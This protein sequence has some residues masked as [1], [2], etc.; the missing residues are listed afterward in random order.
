MRAWCWATH[1]WLDG[2]T[3]QDRI[4]VREGGI[5][6]VQL[7]CH[8]LLEVDQVQVGVLVLVGVDRARVQKH[9]PLVL[10]QAQ[11]PQRQ[12]ISSCQKPRCQ[13]PL[14]P[15]LHATVGAG[16]Q[17]DRQASAEPLHASH[18]AT[19]CST[20]P[21]VELHLSPLVPLLESSRHRFLILCLWLL[22]AHNSWVEPRAD[23]R[24]NQLHHPPHC[25]IGSDVSRTASEPRRARSYW[26]WQQAA[27]SRQGSR[28]DASP[29]DTSNADSTSPL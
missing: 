27:G 26:R 16:R 11:Q 8:R 21:H 3:H 23:Y 9:S 28:H 4:R 13:K 6:N 17:T 2:R 14:W 29:S 22:D 24:S 20:Y 18:R 10:L 7:A 15:R 19:Q 12:F 5:T 25:G 1:G